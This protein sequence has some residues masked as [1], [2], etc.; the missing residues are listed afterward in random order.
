MIERAQGSLGRAT[1]RAGGHVLAYRLTPV[2][3]L[4]IDSCLQL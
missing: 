3:A 1:V 4:C 2:T